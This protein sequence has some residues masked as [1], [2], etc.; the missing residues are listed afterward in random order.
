VKR[1]LVAALAAAGLVAGS[2]AA[3]TQG[4]TKNEIVL[5]SIQDLSGPIA[6]YGKAIR[7]GL[8]MRADAINEAGGINGRK[9]KLVVEDS[10]YD[11]KKAVLAAQKLVQKDKVFAVVGTV[12]TPINMAAMPVQFE[13]NVFNFLPI[14]SAREM[15]EPMSPLKWSFA[16]TYFDQVRAGSKWVVKTKGSKRVCVLYQDDDFGQ[17]ILRGTEAGLK[18]INMQLAER[19]SFKRGATDF[20]S[21]IQRLR[22]ANCDLVVLGTIIRE[23][24]GAV[25]EARKIGWNVEFLG[26]SAA[27][28]TLIPKLGGKMMDGFYTMNTV[29]YPYPDDASKNIREWAQGY[30]A[31]FNEDP[32]IMSVY[33]DLAMTVFADVAQRA[34]PNLTNETFIAALEKYTRPRDMFG[35][36][37]MVFTK[38]KHLATNRARLSQ[39]QNGKWVQVTDYLTE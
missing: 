13:K 30:K 21:Q 6:G 35:A 37:E 7:N 16:A 1:I 9:I 31:K 33:G 15:Y 28:D 36:D 27:Y 25:G 26:S 32:T 4:V 17:E 24:I 12:G 3:Q 11:P 29:N 20:S 23:T 38:T 18:E 22:N 5:G 10:G 8:Q 2:A 14:T 19:T 34:G 39:I